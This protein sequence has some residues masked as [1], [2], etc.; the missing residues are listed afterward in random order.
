MKITGLILFCLYSLASFAQQDGLSI[1]PRPDLSLAPGG[2]AARNFPAVQTSVR[3]TEKLD[4]ATFDFIHGILAS[5]RMHENLKCRVEVHA[6]RE[7]RRFSTGTQLIEALEIELFTD[8]FGPRS[9][10]F[11]FPLGSRMGRWIVNNEDAGP[12]EEIKIET[13]EPNENWFLFQHDGKRLVWAEIG[14]M[15]QFA[16]CLLRR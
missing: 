8:H 10:K 11:T 1:A 5:G 13:P 9:V 6:L 3:A 4:A 7:E 14:N 15:Y 16:P 12:V 2:V